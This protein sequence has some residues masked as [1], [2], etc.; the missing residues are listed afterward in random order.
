MAGSIVSAECAAFDSSAELVLDTFPPSTDA[1][2]FDG[3]PPLSGSTPDQLLP[4]PETSTATSAATSAASADPFA[5]LLP[6]HEEKKEVEDPMGWGEDFQARGLLSKG[7]GAVVSG[8]TNAAIASTPVKRK[9]N[10]DMVLSGQGLL[11]LVRTYGQLLRVA[12]TSEGTMSGVR[13]KRQRKADKKL[14]LYKQQGR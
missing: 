4:T 12:T 7:A 9:S 13:Q 14:C 11:N 8:M 3:M 10:G 6:E 5:P 2:S 1:M